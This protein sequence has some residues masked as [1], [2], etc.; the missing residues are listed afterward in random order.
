MGKI[1]VTVV[2]SLIFLAR[3]SAA[4]YYVDSASGS[5]SNDGSSE[6]AAWKTIAKVNNISFSPGDKILF[7]R[8]CTWREQLVPCSGSESGYVTYGAYG[9]VLLPK[10]ALLGSVNYSSSS[11][12]ENESGNIWK[13]VVITS[14]SIHYT[15]LYD[16]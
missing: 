13:T 14:Y 2:I 9:S 12:W 7:K 4:T 5:D 11:L 8:G 3:L 6:S 10:P 1:F 16:S 15:K